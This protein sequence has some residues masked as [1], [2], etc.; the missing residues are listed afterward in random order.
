MW[1]RAEGETEGICFKHLCLLKQLKMRKIFQG[2]QV[3]KMKFLL[4]IK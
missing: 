4:G 2:V 1:V 3:V